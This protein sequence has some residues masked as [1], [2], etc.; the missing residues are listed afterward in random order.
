MKNLGFGIISPICFC[1]FRPFFFRRRSK[2][3]VSANNDKQPYIRNKVVCTL[4]FN[5]PQRMLGYMNSISVDILWYFVYT[6]EIDLI[7]RL[8]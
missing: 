6:C 1:W 3:K 4:L 7:F 2:T 5:T 8:I